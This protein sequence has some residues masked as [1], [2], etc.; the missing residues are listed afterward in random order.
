MDP[1]T[2][3]RRTNLHAFLE[4]RG[5]RGGHTAPHSHVRLRTTDGVDLGATWL[6]GP[7]P[8]APAVVLCHGFGARASKPAYARLAD[9]LAGHLH[10]LTLDMRGHGRSGGR[11]TLGDRERFDVAAG[12]DWVRTRG[13]ATVGLVGV[14]MGATS[15]LHAAASGVEAAG[16]V[17]VSG[18]AEFDDP[19]QT[20]AMQRLRRLW[21]SPAAR[22][23]M[24]V[25]LGIR[26]I[27]PDRWD[28]PDHPHELAARVAAP[29]LVVHG[30]DDHFFP[31]AAAE[32]LAAASSGRL[33]IEPEGFGHAEDGLTAAFC[34]RLAAAVA[35]GLH[36]GRFP[37]RQDEP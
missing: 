36:T 16:V 23:G 19:P 24:Q 34:E 27:H 12:V 29:V 9:H 6:P 18:P 13:H 7:A 22:F 17:V 8:A 26:L 21:D 25:G 37:E 3:P 15:V 28:R 33:W 11:T 5:W 35:D 32:R 31:P 30:R 1:D 20:A 2:E 4:T 10:V 14:S